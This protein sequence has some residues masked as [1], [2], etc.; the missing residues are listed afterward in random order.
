MFTYHK[1]TVGF[2]LP[3]TCTADD[4]NSAVSQLLGFRIVNGRNFSVVPISDENYCYSK[5]KIQ[6]S[7]RFDNLTVFIL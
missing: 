6:A 2:C 1:P 5:E 7:G 4:L 3:S